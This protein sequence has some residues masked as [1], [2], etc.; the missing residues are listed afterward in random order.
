MEVVTLRWPDDEGLLTH[1]RSVGSPRLML[2]GAD[3]P[4]PEVVDDL[5]DWVRL[6]APDGDI[7]ARTA[8]LERRAESN[9]GPPAIDADGLIHFRG[10]WVSL[11]PVEGRLGRQLVDRYGAVVG[12]D[13]L[14]R[15][16][17][18]DGAPTR[19]ALDVHMLR[20]RR[21]ISPLGLEVRTVRARGYVLQ[22]LGA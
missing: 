7:A 19:N 18:P 1:L 20:L 13:T 5:E 2:V 17:W 3:A 21:R 14:V 16:A 9:G 12:R 10:R 6:P 11:S 4:A 8:T 15:R 22:A